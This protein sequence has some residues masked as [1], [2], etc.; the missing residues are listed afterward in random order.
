MYPFQFIRNW[1]GNWALGTDEYVHQKYGKWFNAIMKGTIPSV[2]Q[3]VPMTTAQKQQMVMPVL[4]F[5]GTRDALV[6]DAEIAR[7]AA[8]DYPSIQIEILES[9][10]MIAIEHAEKVNRELAAFLLKSA[11]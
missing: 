7:N 6:G 1:V 8:S 3:P 11:R 4:L 10:H 9:G 5:L 2:A